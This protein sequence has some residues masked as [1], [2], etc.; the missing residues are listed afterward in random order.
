VRGWSPIWV[1]ALL[2]TATFALATALQPRAAGWERNAKQG[3]AL[4]ALLGDSRKL[5]ADQFLEQADVSFHSGY[6]PSIFDERQAPKDTGHMKSQEGSPEAEE[7]EQKMNFMGPPRDWIEKFGRHF[8][9]TE[10]THLQGGN[11]REILPW[12][13]LSVELDPHRVDT[14]TVASYWL[15]TSLG[16][17]NEAEQFLREGL[18][19]NPGSYELWYELGLLY[20]DNRHDPARARTAWELALKYWEQKEGTQP[21]PDKIEFEKIVVHL[22]SLEEHEGHLERAIEYFTMAL[23][24]SPNPQVVR[25]QI[26]ELEQKLAA[27][28]GTDT[29]NNSARR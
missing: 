29:V 13:R 16:K 12:L 8:M 4:Q 9:I 18:R 26:A 23:R 28:N 1:F 7:H 25:Q 5:F 11:E 3:G 6:Y 22:A 2:L 20:H 17:V 14:Y 19:N 24:S 15:R 27:G 21:E 10:H